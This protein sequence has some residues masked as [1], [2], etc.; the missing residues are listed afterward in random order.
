MLCICLCRGHGGNLHAFGA[1][2]IVAGETDWGSVVWFGSVVLC[3][4]HVAGGGTFFLLSR[5][6]CTKA[7]AGKG[8]RCRVVAARMRLSR[9]KVMY[10][11]TVY[12]GWM[13][14]WAYE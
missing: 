10:V 6:R 4:E 14:R 12:G 13:C 1:S 2:G 11:A 9:G 8:G 7:R 3:G 5:L